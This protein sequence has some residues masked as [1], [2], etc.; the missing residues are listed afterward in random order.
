[1]FSW[2]DLKTHDVPATAEFFAAA[3]GWE[4][5]TDE[6][7]W[8]RTTTITVDGHLIGG[9]SDLSNP[10]YPPGTPPHI[11]LYLEAEDADRRT[12]LAVSLGAR[13]V[14]PP[15]DAGPLGRVATLVDPF[16]AAFSLWERKGFEGWTFPHTVLNAPQRVV[17]AC[18]KPEDACDFY[19]Q[20]TG[21]P[22]FNAEFRQAGTPPVW[23]PAI[24]IGDG[25][26]VQRLTSPE[27]LSVLL[28]G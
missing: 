10:F 17:L 11:A 28:Y 20:T 8:R 2:M 18:A 12:E 16:G 6:T 24:K 19:E 14:V 5:L 26:E 1:M 9:V 27:G 25:T 3:L 13:L 7:D 4:F 15:F 21:R 22:L 23:E